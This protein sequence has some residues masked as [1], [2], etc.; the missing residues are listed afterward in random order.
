MPAMSGWMPAAGNHEN[1]LGNGPIGFAAYQ[2]YFA[3]LGNGG[4][5]DTNGLWYAFT[6]GSV[7]VVS[8]TPSPCSAPVATARNVVSDCR[9]RR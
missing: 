7:R 8:G 3:M 9:Q 1:E 6:V 5:Q 4:D 2:S